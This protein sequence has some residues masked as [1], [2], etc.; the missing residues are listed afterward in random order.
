MNCK[1]EGVGNEHKKCSFC[2]EFSIN[3]GC[4]M[5][6]ACMW[7]RSPL[8]VSVFIVATYVR[9]MPSACYI[10]HDAMLVI[11]L[12]RRVFDFTV[13]NVS[14]VSILYFSRVYA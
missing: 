5:Y 12:Y 10:Y 9:Y 14:N 1:I 13:S 3:H 11:S 2:M 7:F 8:I 4:V 6:D